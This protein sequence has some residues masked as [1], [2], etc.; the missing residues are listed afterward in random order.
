[1]VLNYGSNWDHPIKPFSETGG[2]SG[3][4]FTYS[5]KH[6]LWRELT[7][8]HSLNTFDENTS[9][10]SNDTQSAVKGE[11]NISVNTEIFIKRTLC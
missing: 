4:E 11:G 5:A 6:A 8:I 1:M 3:S 7:K 10:L 2:H 9:R